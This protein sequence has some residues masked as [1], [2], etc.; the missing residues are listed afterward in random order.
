[1]KTTFAAALC[2]A[3]T[4]GWTAGADAA[5]RAAKPSIEGVWAANFVLTIEAPA[6]GVPPLVVPDAEAKAVARAQAQAI[7][8][9][10]GPLDPEVPYLMDG[11][12][13]LPL[14]RGERRS[15]L[16]VEP[17]DGRLPYTPE[18]RKAL[19]ALRGPPD[20]YDNPEQR[21]NLERCLAGVGQAPISTLAFA[22]NLQIVRLKDAVVI[23]TEYGDEVRIA[24]ITDKHRPKVLWGRLGDSIAHWE[25]ATLVVETVGLPDADRFRLQPTFVVSGEATVVERFT[26][27]SDDELL[28]QFTVIDPKVYAAPWLAEFSWYRTDKPMYEHACHEGNYSLP[29]IL[30]GARHQ[31]AEKVAAAAAH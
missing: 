14:V 12:D 22:S 18:V 9:Q 23:H 5:P 4:L 1:M 2:W 19:A 29:N 17:A 15:R 20:S 25:G 13:G 3:L 27:V 6:Q 16:V 21:P 28:Y 30:A 26:A 11:V 8:N 31:E 24:P 7:K 10:F